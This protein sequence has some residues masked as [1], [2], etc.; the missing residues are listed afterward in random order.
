MSL[1]FN[2]IRDLFAP[3]AHPQWARGLK[4]DVAA[5]PS[6]RAAPEPGSSPW[7][8]A[9][10]AKRGSVGLRVWKFFDRLSASPSHSPPTGATP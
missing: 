6:R 5:L 3:L 9:D 10:D 7:G 1:E 8:A 2:T 4:D